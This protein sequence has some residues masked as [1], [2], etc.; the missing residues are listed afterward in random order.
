MTDFGIFA[1]IDTPFNSSIKGTFLNLKPVFQKSPNF[2]ANLFS[3]QNYWVVIF[4]IKIP[5]KTTE[6]FE[7]CLI[8]ARTTFP[9]WFL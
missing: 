4:Q 1:K 2:E 6:E 7:N 3:K 9:Y 5:V 8:R